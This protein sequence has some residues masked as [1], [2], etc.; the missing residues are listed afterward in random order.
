MVEVHHFS[1]HPIRG[2]DAV[3][4]AGE[5]PGG[6]LTPPAYR[7]HRGQPALRE[8]AALL[9]EPVLQLT[10]ENTGDSLPETVSLCHP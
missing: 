10:P 1:V 4:Q 6:C 9:V 8:A 7:V 2:D 3:D 5:V